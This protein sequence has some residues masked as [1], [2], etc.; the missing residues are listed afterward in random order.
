MSTLTPI[1]NHPTSEYFRA[2][3]EFERDLP[4][5]T[6]R[7][8]RDEAFGD[9]HRP[10]FGAGSAQLPVIRNPPSGGGCAEEFSPFSM[11][12]LGGLETV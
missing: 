2:L 6:P 11:S 9:Q 3:I 1:I 8:T 4:A 7:D 10:A 12:Q 5:A